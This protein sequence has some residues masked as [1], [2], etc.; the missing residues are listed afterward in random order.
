[1]LDSLL[2]NGGSGDRPDGFY[3]RPVFDDEVIVLAR[4]NPTGS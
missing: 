3:V 4:I 1:M 2:L